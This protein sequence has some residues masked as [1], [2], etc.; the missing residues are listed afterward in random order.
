MKNA[1]N[2]GTFSFSELAVAG[3]MSKRSIQH[4]SDARLLPADP[5]VARIK[6]V[7]V[8]GALLSAGVPLFAAGRVAAA[9]LTEF[10]TEDGE[11][12]SGLNFLARGLPSDELNRLPEANQN[13][14][15]WYHDALKR[16][17]TIYFP[18]IALSSDAIVEIVDRR[19]VFLSNMS[20]FKILNPFGE[21]PVEASYVGEIQAWT[22]GADCRVR[23]LMH[24]APFDQKSLSFAA[25]AGSIT[26]EANTRRMN[27]IALVKINAS[28]A[29][30]TAFDRLWSHRQ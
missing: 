2:E 18:N 16:C 12:P 7:A 25:S 29:I 9:I 19:L 15:F 3:N 8:V 24:D 21:K 11:A 4:L 1:P 6:R 23:L 17:P 22:R 13:I 14:D 30:R 5:E 27:A 26:A 10:N 20:G 28:L